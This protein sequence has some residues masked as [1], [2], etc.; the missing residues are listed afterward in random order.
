MNLTP[1]KAAH[2]HEWLA[3]PVSPALAARIPSDWAL[4]P[5]HRPSDIE[6]A[7]VVAAL[8]PRKGGIQ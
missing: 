5:S 8:A 7:R 1:H 2:T 6:R 4:V 3:I